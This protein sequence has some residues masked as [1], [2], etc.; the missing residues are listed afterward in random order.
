V[1]ATGILEPVS[2]DTGLLHGSVYADAGSHTHFHVSRFDG[3]HVLALDGDFE[4][5]GSCKDSSPGPLLQCLSLRTAA[6]TLPAQTQMRR[7]EA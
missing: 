2:G 1:P 4:P 3:I 5:D 7:P 6:K